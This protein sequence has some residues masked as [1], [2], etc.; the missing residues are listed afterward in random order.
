MQKLLVINLGQAYVA[1]S[2]YLL[3]IM[4]SQLMSWSPPQGWLKKSNRNSYPFVLAGGGS[5]GGLE[6]VDP[7]PTP[8]S[9]LFFF[10]ICLSLEPSSD[11]L[12]FL[13]RTKHIFAPGL[14]LSDKPCLPEIL[15]CLVEMCRKKPVWTPYHCQITT[16]NLV[17]HMR[18][19]P[20]ELSLIDH[21]WSCQ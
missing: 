17:L 3:A 10:Q 19:T 15:P 14:V 4:E 6:G 21:S 1:Y 2:F 18:G 8:H 16:Y 11:A 7:H 13:C 12:P 20:S 9:N 5:R